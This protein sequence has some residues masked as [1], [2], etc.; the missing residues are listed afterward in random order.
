MPQGKAVAQGKLKQ[1]KMETDKIPLQKVEH[2]KIKHLMRIRMIQSM[3][4]F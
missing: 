3:I 1:H 2:Q 4:I